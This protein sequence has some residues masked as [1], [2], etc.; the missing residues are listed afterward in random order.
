MLKI[1]LRLKFIFLS[2][3][4]VT[5]IMLAVT[6]LFTIREIR[7]KKDAVESQMK[8]IAENTATMQLLDRQDWT[9][10][11]NYISQMITFNNDI[12]YIAIY[13]DRNTLRAHA[14][15]PDLIDSQTRNLPRWMEA[16][17]VK[18]LDE[19]AVAD[20]SR[21]DLRTQ[22]VNIQMGNRILGSVHVGFSLIAIN[23]QLQNAIRLNLGL[24][25]FFF[26]VFVAVSVFIS[27]RL[28]GP[29]ERLSAAMNRVAQGDLQNKIR[30][31]T[32]DEIGQ[33][34]RN[35]NEMVDGLHERKII[36]DLGRDM[37]ATFILSDLAVLVRERIGNEI[38]A[39][40]ARLYIRSEDQPHRFEEITTSGNHKLLYPPIELS[41]EVF[42]FLMNHQDGFMIHDAPDKIL[43]VLKHKR[44]DENGL[45][46][47]LTLKE[48]LFGMLFFALPDGQEK[49]AGKQQQFAALLANQAT[50]A[51]ENAILYRGKQEQERLKREL[52]IAREVQQKLLPATMPR[53]TGYQI[54][55]VCRSAQEVGG[56]YF[57]FFSIDENHL[58]MVVA[59]VSGKGTS[60][61]FYMAELKG[62]M[63]HLV[64]PGMS[65]GQLMIRLNRHLYSN[66]DRHLF[67]TMI[68]G[69]LDIS[70]GEIVFS[71][72]GHNAVLYLDRQGNHRILIPQGI[73]LGLES[74]SIFE[75][76]IEE[77]VVKLSPGDQLVLYTDGITEMM[78]V[79]LEE[80]G[81]ERLI[82]FFLSHHMKGV[83]E[84]RESLLNILMEY[85]GE[86]PQ[87][88]DLTM[89]IIKRDG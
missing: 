22:K 16:N 26:V 70:S 79:K 63:T 71:R 42:S 57:D 59:D 37:S 18:R 15:N 74:G 64:S 69:I 10:Y 52:E 45:I 65:P 48:E 83:T 14:L 7:T 60:A 68:Y 51:L 76:S 77:E 85:M 34:A 46:I 2:T 33:L 53:I 66:V 86:K 47:P 89:I 87:H 25:L 41:D 27:G 19:G 35:F 55:G 73:G 50:M 13:D 31:E 56:D 43:T 61:S 23:N 38:G 36:E 4:L 72:A 84:Q 58:G 39:R 8:R 32:R 29:L 54:D 3:V 78:N 44:K 11:Q 17:I 6:Y 24:A 30:I 62:M 88:D 40:A 21:N 12:V 20:E 5:V 75:Q 81:E 1:T 67:V 9:V 49:F 82:H 28:T 80:Y